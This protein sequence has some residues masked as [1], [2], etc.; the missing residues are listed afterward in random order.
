MSEEQEEKPKVP[1]KME[2]AEK[3]VTFQMSRNKHSLTKTL[4]K[5][6]KNVD[7]AL[8]VVLEVIADAEADPK[9][10]LQ[11]A[12]YIIDTKVRIDDTINKEILSRQIAEV[13]MLQAQQ[14]R[15]VK[16]IV[17]EDGE[18]EDT[19]QARFE[20]NCILRVDTNTL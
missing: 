2:P 18:E 19:V 14:P 1:V 9:I 13:K 11:A 16:T 3:R 7:K 17:P 15:Q 6:D 10:R 8:E 4:K 5:L 20:P 12:Q